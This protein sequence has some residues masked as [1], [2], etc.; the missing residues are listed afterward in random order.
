MLRRLSIFAFGIVV[1]TAILPQDKPQPTQA[2]SNGQVFV[3]VHG[4]FQDGSGW[5]AVVTE[6]EMAGNTAIVVN[7]P[8]KGDD[9]TPSFELTLDTYRDAVVEV[10]SAQA[11]PVILVGHSFGGMVISAVAETVPDQ[12]AAV[13]YVA[14]YLPS[15]GDS[16]L[17]LSS[18]D[19]YSVLGQ[20]GNFSVDEATLLAT[21]PDAVFAN[22]FCPDCDEVQATSVGTS[23]IAEPVIP[24]NQPVTLSD[25]N[26]GSVTKAYVL[27]AQ[28]VVVSPQLQAYM[29]SITPVD[30]VYALNTGHVPF[31][32]APV[33]LAVI[34]MDAASAE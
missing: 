23:Q 12:I 9:T 26:F 30:H 19:R 1:L 8:G 3:L 28:D 13:V 7:L 21:V 4:A 6:L 10:I 24:L 5:D 11:Q 27:T 29:L 18:N 15:N 14:A 2:Q 32:T 31:I 22:A 17:T 20:E 33:E 34:L 25:A 16:L